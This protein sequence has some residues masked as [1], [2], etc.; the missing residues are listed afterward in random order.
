MPKELQRVGAASSLEVVR[1]EKRRRRQMW[2]K[3]VVQSVRQQ[4]FVPRVH[5]DFFIVTAAYGASAHIAKTLRSVA[6]QRYPKRRIHHLVIDDASPDGTS[7]LVRRWIADAAP[8]HDVALWANDANQGGCAN[9]T[10]G[11]RAAPSDSIVLQLDGDDWLPDLEVLSYLN[12][13][14]HDPDLWMTYNSWRTPR[15]RPAIHHYR[16]PE[17]VI[18]GG[19]LRRHSWRS[20][21]LHSFRARLFRHVRDES[22]IDPETGSWWRYAVDQSHYLPMLE[23]AG[24]RA[25]HLDR[26]TYVYNLH[27]ASVLNLRREEQ[28]A[29]ERRIREQAPYVPLDAL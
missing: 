6:C 24:S 12:M 27:E 25:R 28:L 19:E 16:V 29:C 10:R 9:Y 26:F 5:H 21:H 15:G 8:R 17:D 20:S 11:F 13:L 4:V 18:A 3:H 2:F 14:Y 22:L 1:Y 7:D 23:L